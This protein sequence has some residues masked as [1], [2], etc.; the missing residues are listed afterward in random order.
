MM[1][2]KSIRIKTAMPTAVKNFFES[3]LSNDAARF[4]LLVDMFQ[5]DWMVNKYALK[6]NAKIG[7]W[8]EIAS[9]KIE[10]LLNKKQKPC[11]HPAGLLLFK[12][13]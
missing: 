7:L 8:P 2:S 5:E 6:C 13:S 10:F 3:R 9:T 1:K 4:L 11:R 12:T